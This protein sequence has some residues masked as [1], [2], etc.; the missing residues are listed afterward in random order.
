LGYQNHIFLAEKKSQETT[1]NTDRRGNCV[2]Q[3]DPSEKASRLTGEAA[4]VTVGR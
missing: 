1:E 4:G 3:E 2:L